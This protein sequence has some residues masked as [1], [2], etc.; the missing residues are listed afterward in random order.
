MDNLFLYDWLSFTSK[1]DS[2]TS[3]QQLLGF[4][5]GSCF[6]TVRGA[7]GY[8]HR[9]Y[10]G[11]ISIHYGGRAE[12]WVEM[13]GEGCRTFESY[14][15]GAWDTLFEVLLSD[16]GYHITRLDV[17]FDDHEGLIDLP[18]LIRECLEQHFVS[19]FSDYNT[20]LGNRGASV[21]HGRKG[22]SELFFR[23]Y[24]KAAE[25]GLEDTHW[26]RYEMQLRRERAEAFLRHNQR[27]PIGEVFCQVSN[28]Y[29][30]YVTP[31]GADTNKWRWPT[32]PYWE[33]LIQTASKL[34][35]YQTPGVEYNF[36]VLQ[37]YVIG[38]AAASSA[39]YMELVGEDQ[40]LEQ[41]R[42][43]L[44]YSDNPKYRQLI[45]RMKD[46]KME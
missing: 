31:Q 27:L 34:R 45:S 5:D 22:Q 30:R 23:I 7:K 17:A 15:H 20:Q 37:R 1:I 24:D 42:E 19:R 6:E 16:P 4:E 28:T 12:L 32:A 41:I 21:T 2:L 11:G 38:Q 36:H 9:A 39:A 40:F 29:L 26:V 44:Q 43:R 3:L 35:L 8:N 25:R 13:S 18:L 46:A 10:Y 33:R 14:G